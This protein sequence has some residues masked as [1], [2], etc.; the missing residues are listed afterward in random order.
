VDS[1]DTFLNKL[2]EELAE[3]VAGRIIQRLPKPNVIQPR[4]LTVKQ[5]AEY[6]GHTSASIHYLISKNLFPVI[7]RDRL[8]LIDKEDLDK[9]LARLKR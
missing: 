5:A 6:V 3:R 7:R 2:A 8:V 4:Y 1:E 9:A